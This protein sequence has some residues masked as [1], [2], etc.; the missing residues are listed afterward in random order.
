[1]SRKSDVADVADVAVVD[2]AKEKSYHVVATIYDSH[3]ARITSFRP[4][5]MGIDSADVMRNAIVN[6]FATRQSVVVHSVQLIDVNLPDS[7]RGRIAWIRSG[8][9]CPTC[10]SNHANAR[11]DCDDAFC[12]N[13]LIEGP[14]AKR[15]KIDEAALLSKLSSI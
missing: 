12:K 6:H 9:C 1:M 8:S 13:A 4:A 14:R 10:G 5:S 7:L 11:N 2:D 15:T 3:G